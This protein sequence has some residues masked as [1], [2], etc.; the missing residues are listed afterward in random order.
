MVSTSFCQPRKSANKSLNRIHYGI[1]LVVVCFLLSDS[2]VSAQ[3]GSNQIGGV[4]CEHVLAQMGAKMESGLQYLDHLDYIRHFDRVDTNHDGRHSPKEYI[5]NGFH[6]NAM[7]RRG[8]FNAADEDRDG[9]VSRDEYVLNR[10]ITDEA[11]RIVQAMDEDRDGFISQNEFL[12]RTD[13]VLGES[14]AKEVFDAFDLNENGSLMIP[15]YL[16]VWGFWAR[17]GKPSAKQRLGALREAELDDY[18]A[19]VSRS[20]KEGDFEGYAATCHPEGVLVSGSSQSSYPLSRALAR[21]KQGILDTKS[22]KMKASVE[23]RFSHRVGDVTTAHETGIFRYASEV[24]GAKS[25]AFIHFEAL[26]T[27]GQ[28]RWLILMENQKAPASE[29]DWKALGPFDQAER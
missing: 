17:S 21:W 16:R 26:L 4:P 28:D 6:M 2:R 25:V 19:E 22:G 3:R 13:S 18:W 5:D 9:F 10:V 15:E 24:D 27:R 14:L 12:S 1:V 29:D 8:I 11:K 23:F 20:V 7:A